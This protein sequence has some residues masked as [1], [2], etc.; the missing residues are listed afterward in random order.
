LFVGLSVAVHVVV[1]VLSP[2][3][4]QPE[5][6]AVP[7]S[8]VEF[9]LVEPARPEIAEQ[10]QPAPEPPAAAE[11]PP[12]P[13]ELPPPPASNRKV[14]E[15]VARSEKPVVQEP[16]RQP[17]AAQPEQPAESAS[18]D[19]ITVPAAPPAAVSDKPIDL[20]PRAVALSIVPPTAAT[21]EPAPGLHC[22]PDRQ[23]NPSATCSDA[24][25]EAHAQAELDRNLREMAKTIPHLKQREKPRLQ[26][27]SDGTYEYAGHVFVAT[28]GRDGQ[29]NFADAATKAGLQ[30]SMVP[31]RIT[32]DVNDLA[33]SLQHKE[34]YTEEK[35]WFLEQTAE[36]RTKLAD[37][38]HAEEIARSHRALEQELERILVADTSDAQ[39]RASVFA[40]WQDCG[41][42]EQAEDVRHIV[43]VFVRRRMPEGS[44]LGF[45]PRDLAQLNA[46]RSGMR[47]FAP[48]RVGASGAP[49]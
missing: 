17:A 1:A 9:S 45:S 38:F 47:A 12:P 49:G 8:E 29:V 31:V 35:R 7:P 21:P 13:V 48:Y 6:V 2:R 39:K 36:L 46:A 25:A 44:A 42:D 4:V 34:L 19:A 15:P 10:E 33:N 5:L 37:K 16:A 27:K 24:G 41:E 28:I 40:V 3:R 22:S 43:E 11:P 23:Q 32:M 18:A 14:R 26:R 20:S 30:P